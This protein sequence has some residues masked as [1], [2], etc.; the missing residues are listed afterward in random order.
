MSAFL[1]GTANAQSPQLSKADEC[2]LEEMRH[3]VKQSSE[4]YLLGGPGGIVTFNPFGVQIT[5]QECEQKTGDK[6][7]AATDH[8]RQNGF[9]MFFA[10][11]RDL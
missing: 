7:T 10:P 3:Q 1:C 9:G 4:H 8:L 11:A 2:V 5:T 6:A